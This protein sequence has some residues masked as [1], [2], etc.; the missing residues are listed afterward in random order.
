MNERNQNRNKAPRWSSFFATGSGVGASLLP[1]G[2]CPACWPAYAGLLGSLG[3]GVLLNSAFLFPLTAVFLALALF[4]LGHR[5]R[6]RHDYGPL[7]VGTVG[8]AVILLSN[9]A[10]GSTPLLYLGVAALVG[11]S[12]WNSWPRKQKSGCPACA[13]TDDTASSQ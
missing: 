7:G 10:L 1:V 11:A 12:V 5:A 6:S 8:V 13:S 3:L 4:V 9:F 2:I